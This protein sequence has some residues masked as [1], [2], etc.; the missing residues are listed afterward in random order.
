MTRQAITT[1]NFFDIHLLLELELG[2]E[3]VETT[4]SFPKF[5]TV[6]GRFRYFYFRFFFSFPNVSKNK[7]NLFLKSRFFSGTR[8]I[9]VVSFRF[10]VYPKIFR[11]PEKKRLF[12]ERG[13]FKK[14]KRK[15]ERK[16][17][18]TISGWG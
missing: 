4:F 5:R 6:P 12:L 14:R 3:I 15:R 13:Y 16:V 18:S 9:K 2:A 17:V 7:N 1:Q 11:V 10:R 8:N